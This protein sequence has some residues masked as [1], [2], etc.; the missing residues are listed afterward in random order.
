MSGAVTATAATAIGAKTGAEARSTATPAAARAKG[1]ENAA[2][3]VVLPEGGGGIRA[4]RSKTRTRSDGCVGTKFG[5]SQCKLR[6]H[7]AGSCVAAPKIGIA[8][9]SC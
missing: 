6:H 1:R 7:L 8:V 5:Q 3:I 9:Q 2:G 4:E